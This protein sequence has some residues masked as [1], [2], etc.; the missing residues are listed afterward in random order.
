MTVGD[1]ATARGTVQ[2][3]DGDRVTCEVSLGLQTGAEALRGVATVRLPEA[4][5]D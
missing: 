4:T 2:A 1:T 5:E 3:V